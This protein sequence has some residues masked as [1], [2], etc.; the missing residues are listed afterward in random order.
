MVAA[1]PHKQERYG[2]DRAGYYGKHRDFREMAGGEPDA[3]RQL[4]MRGDAAPTPSCPP[5]FRFLSGGG[6]LPTAAWAFCHCS[7]V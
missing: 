6:T 7:S 4:G 5:P 3:L 2:R 1:M